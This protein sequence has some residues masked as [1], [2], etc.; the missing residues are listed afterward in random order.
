VEHDPTEILTSQVSCAVEVLGKIRCTATGCG[1]DRNHESAR[2]GGCVGAG[3]RQAIHP[4]IV[5]QDRRTA[6]QCSELEAGGV[7]ETVSSK[8]GLVLDPYFSATK[9]AWIL[10]HVPGARSRAE[11]GELAFGTVDSW[12]IWP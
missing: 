11:K 6:S 5:W 1:G 2:D 10:D 4:A 3:D 9:V 8:T 12:L 7:G